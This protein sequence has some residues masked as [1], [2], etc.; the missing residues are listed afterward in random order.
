MLG[1][2]YINVYINSIVSLCIDGYELKFFLFLSLFSV[3]RYEIRFW[4]AIECLFHIEKSP[5]ESA[6]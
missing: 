1:D 4:L 3:N 5:A 2:I 6:S